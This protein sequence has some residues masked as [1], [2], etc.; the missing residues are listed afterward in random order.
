LSK[1][2]AG[3]NADACEHGQST[4]TSQE[5][6]ASVADADNQL[7]AMEKLLNVFAISGRHDGKTLS[8]FHCNFDE[9]H[10]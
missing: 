8:F 10:A 7:I 6:S 2:I 3:K 9:T 5:F 1:Y 4:A